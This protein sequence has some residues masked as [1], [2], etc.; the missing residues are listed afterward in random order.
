LAFPYDTHGGTVLVTVYGFRYYDAET[1][2]WP[3]RDPI[4]EQGGLNLYAMVGN[5]LINELDFLGMITVDQLI[6]VFSELE[7]ARLSCKDNHDIDLDKEFN[8]QYDKFI[9][10]NRDFKKAFKKTKKNYDSVKNLTQNVTGSVSKFIAVREILEDAY[11]F[12]FQGASSL[13][14]WN[15]KVKIPIDDAFKKVDAFVTFTDLVTEED[16][17]MLTLKGLDLFGGSSKLLAFGPSYYKEAYSGLTNALAATGLKAMSR[18][19]SD[20]ELCCMIGSE[21][22]AKQTIKKRVGTVADLLN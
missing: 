2:R 16:P 4:A 14:E 13:A 7:A 12:K 22:G 11:E 15:E 1:G 18:I 8:K 20:I 17:I 3:N 9:D 19:A 6:E 21:K 5:D 10:A